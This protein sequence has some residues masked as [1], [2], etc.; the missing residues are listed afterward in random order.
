MNQNESRQPQLDPLSRQ[1]ILIL[2]GI[3][4][5]IL[6]I[7]GNLW[8]MIGNV[9]LLAWQITGVACLQGVAI[10]IGIIAASSILYAV[11]GNYR[12]SVDVYLEF[13]LRPLALPDVLWLGLLPGLSEEFLFRGIMLPALGMGWAALGVSSLIF[14]VLHISGVQQWSYAVWA[15]IIGLVLG[16]SAIATGNLFVPILAHIIT[17]FT[18]SLIWKLRNRP[19]ST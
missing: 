1:Q 13:V 5:L 15:A 16:Y 2:M 6:F 11:W 3:T 9:D 10:A 12:E 7:I 18:S 14:G 4:A 8:R 17:N 19:A